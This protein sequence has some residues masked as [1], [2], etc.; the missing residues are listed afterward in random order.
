M[1]YVYM[2]YVLFKFVILS[3]MKNLFAF[4]FVLTDPSLCSG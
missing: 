1:M 3:E 2:L 4:K